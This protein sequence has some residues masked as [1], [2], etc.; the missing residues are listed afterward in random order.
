M[1]VFGRAS[2]SQATEH[3]IDLSIDGGAGFSIQ[4]LEDSMVRVRYKPA[5]GYKETRTWAIAPT[6][7]EDV[8]WQGRQRDDASGF[9]RPKAQLIETPQQ[10]TLRTGALCC[11]QISR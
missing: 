4:V 11:S 10:L 7:G 9:S 6:A 1:K 3:G 5:S 8:A 2:V